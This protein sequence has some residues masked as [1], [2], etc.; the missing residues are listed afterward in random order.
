M[1]MSVPQRTALLLG[2][3]GRLPFLGHFR[4]C[5]DS[6]KVRF[7]GAGRVAARDDAEAAFEAARRIEHVLCSVEATSRGAGLH[8]MWSRLMRLPGAAL[9]SKQ[10]ADLTVVLVAEDSGGI[11]ATAHG[12]G[13]LW[14]IEAGQDEGV[15]L[16]HEGH[17]LLG[18]PGLAQ[19]MCGTLSIDPRIEALVAAPFGL[20]MGPPTRATIGVLCG[21][22]A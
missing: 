4:F 10:G 18:E 13:A 7:A 8:E 11:E 19:E 17:P 21:V 1:P 12:V 3:P 14:G 5:F 16:V 2:E 6:G 15:S 9:G 20:V 22:H